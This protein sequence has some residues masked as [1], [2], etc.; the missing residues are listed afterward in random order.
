MKIKE[1]N[2][3]S[4][5]I[6][7]T[8]AEGLIVVSPEGKILAVNE[9][10]E[11]MS[12]YQADDI[13]GESCM[14]LD[15]SVCP[16]NREEKRYNWCGLFDMERIER[17]RCSLRKQDGSYIS[18]MK[19][20]TI[21]KNSQGQTTGALEVITDI[22]EFDLLD[23]RVDQLSRQLSEEGEFYDIIGKSEPIKKVF[24]L[25]SKAAQS[26]APIIILGES[27]TG[28]ELVAQAIHKLGRRKDK[29]Y[30]QLNCAALNESL[31]ESELF[32]HVK[33][34]FTGAIRHR[35]GRFEAAKGGDIFLDEIG[36][37]PLSIQIKLL[38]VLEQNKIER[39]GDHD[40]IDVDVRLITATNKNLKTQI[41]RGIF[42][43][44]FFYRINVI[45]INIPPLRERKEDIPLLVN[46]FIK[47]LR[48]R[49]GKDI[50]GLHATVLNFFMQ[51]SWP[52]NIRELK[53]ALEYAFV[54]TEHGLIDMN[55]LPKFED[56]PLNIDN[57]ENELINENDPPKKTALINALKQ[58]NGN[59]SQAAKILGVNRGTV[60]N[61]MKRFGI[62]MERLVRS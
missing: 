12:G 43:E 25:M 3:Y 58:A 17:K 38:R 9:S 28:K 21:I 8:M 22:T 29:P 15:C 13:I 62:D 46:Y 57:N 48:K 26:D 34:A 41:E 35:I 59:Q 20:A 45:P 11:K 55:H 31:L 50:T 1:I 39:V 60:W 19:N 27:G 61:R 56:R 53:N 2:K 4:E 10:F 54:L 40:S 7:E 6:V 24:D 16:K 52:G 36:D 23:Q 37:A 51:Y 49:T 14:M 42:R 44:D 30:V 33:G 5:K 18:V 32:G 47:R